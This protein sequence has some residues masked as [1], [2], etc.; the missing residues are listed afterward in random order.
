MPA[1]N[2]VPN[3]I[4][5]IEQT[6]RR[7]WA[8]ASWIRISA[9]SA[10]D[11]EQRWP[12]F[13]AAR[14]TTPLPWEGGRRTPSTHPPRPRTCTWRYCSNGMP[15]GC[16]DDELPWARSAASELD[17]KYLYVCHAEVNAVLNKNAASLK[18]C[19]VRAQWLY[20]C[21]WLLTVHWLQCPLLIPW[22][23]YTSHYSPV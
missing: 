22:R 5:R 15:R 11:S 6:L 4:P 2:L 21:P 3:N 13:S 16:S 20:G 7:K 23:S 19:K 12:P 17:T 18:G 14:R 8:R 10:S 1:H 9:L